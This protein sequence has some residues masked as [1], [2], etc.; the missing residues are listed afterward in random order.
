MSGSSTGGFSVSFLFSKKESKITCPKVRDPIIPG[1]KK[2]TFTTCD[3]YAVD[4]VVLKADVWVETDTGYPVLINE[5]TYSTDKVLQDNITAE[6]PYFDGTVPTDKSYLQVP[7][8]TKIDDFRTTSSSSFT[9]KLANLLFGRSYLNL[10]SI[11]KSLKSLKTDKTAVGAFLRRSEMERLKDSIIRLPKFNLM[12]AGV[13]GMSD[14]DKETRD[15]EAPVIPQ[16]F[17][18]RQ[19]FGYCKNVISDITDQKNCG[20]CWAMSTAG[21]I[22]DRACINNIST[23]AY[24]PQYMVDCYM[25]QLGCNGGIVGTVFL[26]MN[27]YGIVP[28]TCVPFEA[29]D[30]NCP[31]RCS[32]G[33]AITE[34]MK[35]RP[36]RYVSPYDK[37]NKRNVEAIQKEIMLNG[38][39][40]TSFLVFEKFMTLDKSIYIRQASEKFKGGHMVRIIGW[41]VEN[42][43]DYWLVAN[44]WGTDWDENGLF[45]IRRGYNECN[46]ESTVIASYFQ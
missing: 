29:R 16:F 28:E 17:D 45:R 20:S 23:V 4:V 34:D 19:Q 32:N 11:K 35:I 36:A 14:F 6:Y 12:A 44:S 10:A 43:V 3:H 31:T 15:I 26:D 42:G 27:K 40:A 38:P 13:E 8:G 46:I 41:G 39:V 30:M 24:S 25:N 2:R 22:S 37:D 9:S 7:E 1:H 33:S 18:A 21:V 5:R